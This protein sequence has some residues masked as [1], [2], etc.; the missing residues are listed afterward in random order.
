MSASCRDSLF[1]AIRFW[2]KSSAVRLDRITMPCWPTCILE[3]VAVVWIQDSQNSLDV[4]P[5]C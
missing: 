3:R 2:Q 4:V 1:I 5:C